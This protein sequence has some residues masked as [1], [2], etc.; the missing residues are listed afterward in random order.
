MN[1]LRG[2]ADVAIFCFPNMVPYRAEDLS[3]HRSCLA[4]NDREIAKSLSLAADPGDDKFQDASANQQGLEQGRC[5][6]LN[7]RRLLVRGGVCVRVEYATMQR[8]ELSPLELAHVAF[9]EG[10]LEDSVKRRKPRQWFRL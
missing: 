1:V 2:K 9:E 3:A 7:L 8:H 5:I 10:S 4:E 6:S